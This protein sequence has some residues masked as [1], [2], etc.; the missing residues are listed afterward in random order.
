MARSGG[1]AIVDSK[2]GE[3]T[4]ITLKAHVPLPWILDSS[5]EQ[6]A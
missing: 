6:A 3:G 2:L 1:V 5:Q 4:C